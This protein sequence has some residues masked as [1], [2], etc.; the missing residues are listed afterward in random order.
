MYRETTFALFNS[1]GNSSLGIQDLKII[2]KGLHDELPQVLI[3]GIF[4]LNG[5]CD[6]FGFWNIFKISSWEE[7]VDVRDWSV[8]GS[9]LVGSVLL[10]C[11][12]EHCYAKSLVKKFCFLEILVIAIVM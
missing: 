10:L 1:E 3:T 8:L 6:L 7:L 5:P 9:K 4:I 12:I 11:I 2:S